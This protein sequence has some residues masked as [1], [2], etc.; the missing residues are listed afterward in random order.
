MWGWSAHLP[1]HHGRP[2]Q[3]FWEEYKVTLLKPSQICQTQTNSGMDGDSMDVVSMVDFL[4]G[5]V[6]QRIFGLSTAAPLG[7]SKWSAP[8][9][10]SMSVWAV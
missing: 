10:G 1:A 8:H 5:G 7:N 3:H 4:D 6:D 2:V 9:K